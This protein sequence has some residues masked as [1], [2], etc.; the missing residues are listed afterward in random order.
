MS[1]CTLISWQGHFGK[2]DAHHTLCVATAVAQ[3]AAYAMEG[4]GS[5][6]FQ[7]HAE[8]G[9]ETSPALDVMLLT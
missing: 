5:I 3:A 2:D 6:N 9:L 4:A 7:M 8:I 1:L